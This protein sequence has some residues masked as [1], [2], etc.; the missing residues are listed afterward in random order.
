[1]KGTLYSMIAFI[2]PAAI[3]TVVLAANGIYPFGEKSILIYDLRSQY[4]DFFASLQKG[5]N[6]FYTFE[7]AFGGDFFSLTAYYLMSPFNMI[8]MLSWNDIISAIT[9]IYYLK[10]MTAG[11]TLS[12]YLQR[13]RLFALD[14]GFT[15]LLAAVYTFCG[16]AVM[17]AQNIM[18]LDAL[19]LLPLIA[20][21]TEILVSEGRQKW[22]AV[23]IAAAMVINFY[24]GFMLA[25]FSFVY[26]L[27]LQLTIEHDGKGRTLQRYITAVFTGLSLSSVIVFTAYNKLALTKLSEENILFQAGK[28]IFDNI[29]EIFDLVFYA[30]LVVGVICVVLIIHDK[31]DG[32]DIRVTAKP[33]M[34]F[35]IT[36]VSAVA[37]AFYCVINFDMFIAAIKKYLPFRFD[38]DSPQ[39]YCSSVCVILAIMLIIFW[40]LDKKTKTP[41][42]FTLCLWVFLPV[43]LP[44]LDLVLHSGQTPISFPG[45][46]SFIISFVIILMAAYSLSLIKLDLLRGSIPTVV[47]L[48]ASVII[49]FE[50]TSNA[51]L[52]FRY[53]EDVYYGYYPKESYDSF[54]SVNNDALTMAGNNT[55]IEKTYYRYL[56]DSMALGYRGLTHY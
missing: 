36:V 24:M 37:A 13:T 52:A 46:Y 31:R 43:V 26:M 47:T 19:W 54:M 3:L 12:V 22:F 4:V 5:G 18:W 39:L 23:V 15:P 45:R 38:L 41:Q 56:N 2:L 9:V 44:E 25:I 30:S 16:F 34:V 8:I 55:R 17:Y 35:M 32:T 53:N 6:L 21:T 20:W 10:L 51:V 1:M 11:L 27:F 28:N 48:T 14:T 29:S 7:R 40:I 42:Y 49:I 50:L 33:G